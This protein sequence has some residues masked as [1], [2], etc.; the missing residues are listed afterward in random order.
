[1]IKEQLKKLLPEPIVALLRIPRHWFYTIKGFDYRLA[2]KGELR[3]QRTCMSK[4]M[5]KAMFSFTDSWKEGEPY[6]VSDISRQAMENIFS[7]L[8][9]WKEGD[10]YFAS[11][12]FKYFFSSSNEYQL[13]CKEMLDKKCLEIG[14]G[15]A[16]D[17]S[18]MPWIR[19]RIVIEPLANALKQF[20]LENFGRTLFTDTM[21]TFSQEAEQHISSLDNAINGFILCDNMLDHSSDPRTILKNLSL[22]AAKGCKLLFWSDLWHWK[23]LNE[24]HRNITKSKDAFK[25]SLIDLGFRIDRTISTLKRLDGSTTEYGCIATK[26]R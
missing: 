15:L 10:P 6:I 7:T 17:I 8:D 12:R 21:R 14:G 2:Q 19:S 1:M 25:K 18:L 11:Q 13:F 23:G 26:I 20:Q 9:S 4:Q 24:N 16:S 5:E 22:Y 3:H